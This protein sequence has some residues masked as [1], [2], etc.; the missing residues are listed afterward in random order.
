MNPRPPRFAQK[1]LL[2]FLKK[3]L[4]EEI[5][6]DLDECYYRSVQKRSQGRAH[7][8]YW[9]QVFNY[10]RPFALKQTKINRLMIT[11]MKTNIKYTFR[12]SKRNPLITTASLSS[13]VLG[14]FG[15]FLIYLW[16]DSELTTDKFHSKYDRLYLPAVQQSALDS[17][18][19]INTKLMF[20]TDYSKY[21]EI[22]Q[23]IQ[24]IYLNPERIKFEY[25]NTEYQG[26]GLIADSIF[27]DVFDF[28]LL[29]GDPDKILSDP[30]NIVLTE[31]FAKKIFGDRNPLGEAIRIDDMSTFIVAGLLQDIPSNSSFTFDFLLPIHA[32]SWWGQIGIEFLVVN[33]SFEINTF[34]E[35]IKEIGRDHPQ[36]KESTAS[37]LPFSEVYFD[38]QLKEEIFSRQGNM[39]DVYTMMGV[40]I[41][42]LLVSILNFTNMQSTLLL[43]QGKSRGIKQ[44]HGAGKIDYFQELL[45][46]RT[47][48]ASVATLIVLFLYILVQD[49]YLTFLT[50]SV[51]RSVVEIFGI[52]LLSC[53]SFVFVST[54][55]SL[56][57][58]SGI[59]W[60]EVL[61]SRKTNLQT[62]F[63]GKAL[64]TAQYGFAIILLV[65]SLTVSKQFN[66]MKNKDLGFDSTNLITVKFL[67]RI[68][69]KGDDK[70]FGKESQQQEKDYLFLK[71]ELSLL[72]GVEEKSQSALPFTSGF[73]GM[74]WKLAGSDFEYTE[75][76]VLTVDPDY[77]ELLDLRLV[78]GRFYSDSI[79]Q[80]RQQKVVINKAAMDYWGID[81]LEKSRLESSHWG[82]NEKPFQVIGVVEDF[83][84][85][86]LSRK[87]EPLIMVY[88]RDADR[89]FSLR[90]AEKSFSQTMSSLENIFHKLDPNKAFTYELLHDRIASQYEKE[91]KLAQTLLLFTLVAL[92]LSSLGLF[93][94]ALYD[95]QKRTKEIGIRKVNGATTQQ[96]IVLLS[97]DFVRWVV[98]AFVL[99]VPLAWY[100][101]DEWLA[102]FAN[103]TQLNWWVFASAGA[104]ALF[105]AII[106]TIGQS[107][108]AARRNPI[109]ALR[110]E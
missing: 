110:Y 4:A 11:P 66:Y 35:K 5:L 44:I 3:D 99:A 7:L 6:G 55:L 85:E 31:S 93:T 59:S 49:A 100:A 57:Q 40:A 68:K 89:P 51:D 101:M 87:I 46:S 63:A 95:T 90:I 103:R 82:D 83:H 2:W 30:A 92:L 71:N 107:F 36:F 48:Y 33:K 47:L 10:L 15:S 75:I 28:Q 17:Y 81:N 104:F 52:I 94:L 27:F 54:M 67:D 97:K 32:K 56:L 26:A 21:P 13:L 22:E 53:L 74:P 106:T 12:I 16:V 80:S 105:L 58:S 34:N 29:V 64:T 37:V 23:S 78:A 18:D 70:L 79:D 38:L 60:T 45:V 102:N 19:P 62:I 88:H 65:A 39:M 25:Q 9:Y 96:I 50:L 72:P 73:Y 24:T 1:L 77:M 61:F 98:L 91:E 86:H 84:Y 14:I 69:Y 20:N 43:T 109:H 42:L 41:I 108:R 76:D 8:N